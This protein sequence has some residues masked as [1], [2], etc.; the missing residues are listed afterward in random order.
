M[1]YPISSRGRE[2]WRARAWA[3][4]VAHVGGWR[5]MYQSTVYLLNT[6]YQITTVFNRLTNKAT[7][8]FQFRD[9]RV[10]EDFRI[11]GFRRCVLPTVVDSRVPSSA[12]TPINRPTSKPTSRP[13]TTQSAIPATSIIYTGVVRTYH[14]NHKQE[15][16]TGLATGWSG[17]PKSPEGRLGQSVLHSDTATCTNSAHRILQ[18]MGFRDRHINGTPSKSNWQL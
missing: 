18:R 4:A 17:C 2:T 3:A 11:E 12:C 14:K 1:L 16:E 10:F 5:T 6:R 7:Q 8:K 9:M 13:Y 15:T